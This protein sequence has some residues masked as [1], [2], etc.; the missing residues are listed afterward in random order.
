MVMHFAEPWAF[1]GFLPVTALALIMI[2]YRKGN[3]FRSRFFLCIT[4]LSL[5]V[6][7]LARPQMGHV[8]TNSQ[9]ARFQMFLA[10]DVSNSMLATDVTPSRM[11]FSITFAEKLIQELKG[12]KVALFPFALDGYMQMPLTNDLAAAADM[13]S[14]LNPNVTTNQGTDISASLE[15][16]FRYIARLERAAKA[17]GAEWFPTQVVLL[18]DGESHYPI[19]DEIT[20]LYRNARIPIF[21]VGIGTASGS[22]IPTERRLGG[23]DTLRDRTGQV[24]RTQLHAEMLQRISSL[25]GGDYFTA[26]F[27]EVDRLAKRLTQS[28]EIGKLSTSFKADKE[29]FPL[30]FLIALLLLMAEFASGQWEYAIRGIALGW[31]L[32][33]VASPMVSHAQT[34]SDRIADSA[35]VPGAQ[36]NESSADVDGMDDETRAILEYNNATV[37]TRQN[38]LIKAA[39]MFQESSLLTQDPTLKKKALYNLGNTFLKQGDL[40]QAI[41]SLQQAY[42]V[43]TKTKEFNT[44]ANKKI[45]DELALAYRLLEEMKKQ[46]QK[47]GNGKGNSQGDDDKPGSAPQDQ[48]GPQKFKA[49]DFDGAQKQR[50]FDL[51]AAEEQEALQRIQEQ[52]NQNHVSKLNE[53]PW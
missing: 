35:T 39:E 6:L 33:W 1:W 2:H 48:K 26:Q 50:I 51:V 7:G 17:N 25:S 5:C 13:I 19:R 38:N 18:S 42:E 21:T 47:D 11:D 41:D 30:C 53:K 29:F 14:S 15:T 27:N 32:F 28:A 9:T 44:E 3:R 12:V 45:S 34:T 46:Q 20:R 52:K 36:N 23:R 16:L 24:V 37:L 10:M 8:A 49:Q 31:L 40:E 4:A 43:K 22:T